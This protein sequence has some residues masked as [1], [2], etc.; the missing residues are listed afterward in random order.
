MDRELKNHWSNLIRPLFKQ[1]ADLRVRDS[2]DYYE[3]VVSW[4]LG[5]DSSRPSKRSKRMRIVVPWETV[6]D[7]QNKK[8][9]QQKNDDKKLVQFIKAN[10]E[11]FDPNHDNP[12]EVGPPEVVWVAGSGVLNS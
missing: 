8:K 6:T 2:I 12:I 10:L 11:N 5:T 1:G 9:L 3:V 4:K 7:Y